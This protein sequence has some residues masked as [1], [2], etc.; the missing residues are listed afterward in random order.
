MKQRVNTI[1][2]LRGF[3]L[4]GILIA[5]M[6]IFQYGMFGKDK[7]EHFQLSSFDTVSYVWTKIFVEGSFLP[8]FI[9]LFGYSMM[10]LK[11]KLE[12]NNMKV[13]RHFVRRFILFLTLGLLH[14]IFIWEG[15]I[16]LMYGCIGLFMLMFINRKR[17][18]L[19]VWAIALLFLN[20]FM[21]FG[22]Y[23][24]TDKEIEKMESY[25][26][27][28]TVAYSSE[29]YADALGF[30]YSDE[31]PF[32]FPDYFYIVFLFITPLIISPLLLF[33]MYGAKSNWFT[34]PRKE[35][36]LYI[37]GAIIFGIVGL[38]LKS[39]H[40]IMNDLS[41]TTGAYSVGA[42]LLAIGYI[43]GFAIL[44]TKVNRKVMSYIE[45]VG[46]LSLTNYLVQSII[47]TSLFYGYGMGLFGRLGVFQGI[48]LAFFI[49]AMQI[50]FSHYYLKFFKIGPFE[51][52]MRIFTYLSWNGQP[53]R[54]KKKV[55]EEVA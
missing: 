51:K 5:N 42:I 3:S 52:V 34:D 12:K 41:W 20:S 8:I 1:D 15:D 46:R 40:Y 6:L 44:Y 22:S 31:T 43:F 17:K 47:C 13:K 23:E 29:S 14:S 21:G 26:E 11:E 30:R 18:T 45:K 39:S 55:V 35:K 7:P 10:K 49:F 27:K 19:L 54:R 4:L 50:L 9:F 28:E 53:K 25:I 36:R 2:A 48:L 32:D 37:R 24:E 33:G 38:L 16:L